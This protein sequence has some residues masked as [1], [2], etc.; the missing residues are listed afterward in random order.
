VTFNNVPLDLRL[1]IKNHSPMGFEWG[2]NGSGPRQLALAILTK[3]TSDEIAIEYYDEFCKIF[4]ESINEDE[5][6]I[7]NQIIQKWLAEK[8]IEAIKPILT[9]RFGLFSSDNKNFNMFLDG[10]KL[11][12]KQEHYDKYN[13]Y[14]T[15]KENTVYCDFIEIKDLF[16]KDLPDN[17]FFNFSEREQAPYEQTLVA[18]NLTLYALS[19]EET[20]TEILFWYRLELET[21][22][23]KQNP[24]H[25]MQEFSSKLNNLS[26]I[27]IEIDQLEDGAYILEF[28]FCSEDKEKSLADIVTKAVEVI[29]DLYT[30][31]LNL[32]KSNMFEAIF[33]L[34][35]EYKG[36]AK[37]Y[38]I[39][40]EEFLSDLSIQADV[41]IEQQELETVLKVIPK[42][43][44]EALEKILK[45][46][47]VY[48][49]APVVSRQMKTNEMLEAEVAISK[50]QSQC[51]HL[52]SQLMLKDATII[53][54]RS[55]IESKNLM[56][57]GATNI[58][59][60]AGF[61]LETITKNKTILI[62]SL[63]K[64]NLNGAEIDKKTFFSSFRTAISVLGNK[65]EL[66]L[67]KEKL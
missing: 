22:R 10:I 57:E 34:P 29:V 35:K 7:K 33:E 47:Q 15:D 64:V 19:N 12:E 26:N 25:I 27:N 42:S 32:Q 55:T 16:I 60:E 28:S 44:D 45:A 36:I 50:L 49:S 13:T 51:M 43:K 1:D 24:I 3:F 21:F 56:I 4:I 66:E 11:G 17:I 54:Q 31:T 8:S 46:L 6:E 23:G 9:P 18:D 38:L 5:W 53:Q 30:E 58:F 63:K 41:N 52:E 67:K 20:K 48:I 39:Y 65:F 59:Y 2:Y 14:F 37:Q 40:F 62:D 61:E